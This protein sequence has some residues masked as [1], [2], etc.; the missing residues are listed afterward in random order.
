[1]V[2]LLLNVAGGWLPAFLNN[3]TRIDIEF[4]SNIL[5]HYTESA[6]HLDTVYIHSDGYVCLSC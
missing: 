4:E 1:M 3:H 2:L 6:V 5:P